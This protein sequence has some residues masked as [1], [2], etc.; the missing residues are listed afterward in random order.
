M[1]ADD[2]LVGV[3]SEWEKVNILNSYPF[4]ES[5]PP[6]NLLTC[7]ITQTDNKLL[8]KSILGIDD[9]YVNSFSNSKKKINYLSN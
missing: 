6:A 9:S 4:D 2:S 1:I 3:V 7:W 5:I 8:K